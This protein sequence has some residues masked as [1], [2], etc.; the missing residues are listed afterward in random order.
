VGADQDALRVEEVHDNRGRF[1][2]ESPIDLEVPIAELAVNE[3]GAATDPMEG[4]GQD[5]GEVT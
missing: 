1:L 5:L 3:R 4:I 2:R